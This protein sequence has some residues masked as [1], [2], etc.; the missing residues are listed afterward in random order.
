MKFS[1]VAPLFLAG[2]SA[3]STPSRELSTVLG[4]LSRVQ[5]AID[6]LDRAGQAFTGD[7]TSLFDTSTSLITIINDGAAE[8]KASVPALSVH[9]AIGLI[10]P[11]K[12][13]GQHAQV[14]ADDFV[15]A[16]FEVEKAGACDVVET[17]VSAIAEASDSLN[18]VILG[19]VP[20]SLQDTARHL[21]GPLSATLSGSKASFAKGSCNN[22]A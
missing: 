15:A 9:D 22:K 16:R 2:A 5:N 8:I 6:A 11:T 4:V 10:H 1:I 12:A 7:L 18:E 19:K 3:H 17:Q 14:L 13:L 20:Q 21:A